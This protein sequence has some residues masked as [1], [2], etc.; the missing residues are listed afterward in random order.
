VRGILDVRVGIEQHVGVGPGVKRAPDEPAGVG[1]VRRETASH[2]IVRAAG[3]DEHE[4]VHDE[5]R[6]GHRAP[7]LRVDVPDPPELPAG[8][9]VEGG[10]IAGEQRDVELAARMV[11][12]P[13]GPDVV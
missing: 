11:A 4:V 12:D 10:E 6:G 5:W 9:R 13:A 8:L 3:P 1:I 7:E 2:T